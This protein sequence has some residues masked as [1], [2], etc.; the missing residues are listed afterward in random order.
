MIKTIISLVILLVTTI[1]AKA[2]QLA[3]LSKDQ[4][5]QATIYLQKQPKVLLWC[6]CCDKSPKQIIKVSK[7]YFEHTGNKEF[8]HIFLEGINTSGKKIKEELDL[9]YVFIKKDGK[10]YCVGSELQY[11]CNPCTE[12][13]K[14]K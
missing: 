4:A 14:W 1:S 3:Y 12:S 8:Y 11:K 5:E 6:A 13:F 10:A 7:V 9:A 2:D